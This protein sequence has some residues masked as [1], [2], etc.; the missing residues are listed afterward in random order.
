MQ[1]AFQRHPEI[2]GPDRFKTEGRWM[3]WPHREAHGYGHDEGVDLVAAQTKVWGEGLCAI[4]TKFNDTSV[5]HKAAVD[6]FRSA[7]SAA[8]PPAFVPDAVR[9]SP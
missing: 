7:S 3:E 5:I 8:S 1:Y 2:Y 9:R 6:P 4:Q